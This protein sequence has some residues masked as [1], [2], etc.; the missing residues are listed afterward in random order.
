MFDAFRFPHTIIYTYRKNGFR[1]A[2]E[3]AMQYA[4]APVTQDEAAAYVNYVIRNPLYQRT[5][6]HG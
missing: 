1:L 3:R 4:K 2:L 5:E 6:A